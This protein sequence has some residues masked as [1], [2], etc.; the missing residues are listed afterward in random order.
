MTALSCFMPLIA[1]FTHLLGLIPRSAFLTPALILN[2]VFTG[3][4][5]RL[6]TLTLLPLS[7]S[8]RLTPFVKLTTYDFVA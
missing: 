6:A 1:D 5:H 4:G 7:V 2:G 8:S 3:P